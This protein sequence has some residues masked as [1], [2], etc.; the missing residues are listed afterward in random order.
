[1]SER[2]NQTFTIPIPAPTAEAAIVGG[3]AIASLF[4]FCQK[5]KLPAPE[6]TFSSGPPFSVKLQVNDALFKA[7]GFQNKQDAKRTVAAAAVQHLQESGHPYFTTSSEGG[8]NFI[9]LLCNWCAANMKEQP[10]YFIWADGQGS[11]NGPWKCRARVAGQYFHSYKSFS[12]KQDAKESAARHAFKALAEEASQKSS[13]SPAVVRNDPLNDNA[14]RISSVS[15]GKNTMCEMN[16]TA[17]R[18]ESE[19]LRQYLQRADRA[20]EPDNWRPRKAIVNAWLIG[21]RLQTVPLR[22]ITFLDYYLVD[23]GLLK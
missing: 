8:L 22:W 11:A 9:S 5:N 15:N 3:A 10:E 13:G 4:V 16:L 12:R 21:V 23:S 20:L 7:D 2:A 14:S 17:T 1:M 6:Y 18:R 19:S